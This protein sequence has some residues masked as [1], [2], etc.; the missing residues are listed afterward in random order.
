M[1]KRVIDAVDGPGFLV[2]RC[3]RPWGV[4]ALKLLSEKIAPLET[5]DR[6][7]RLG[8]G[9]RMGPFE[10]MDLVGVDVGLAV[11][12]SF[13][14]QSFGE[15]RWQPSPITVKTVAAGR[16]GRKSKRGY[17]DYRDG[18]DSLPRPRP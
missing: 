1:G 17:Y 13:Y 4:E 10:L 3:N 7:M 18:T 16:L 9:F 15:P 14:E 6:I 8:G 12:R 11:S 2:N 5:I